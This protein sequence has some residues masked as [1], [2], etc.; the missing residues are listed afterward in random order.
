MGSIPKEVFV[1][2][3]I[4]KEPVDFGRIFRQTYLRGK[5]GFVML[6]LIEFRKII[7]ASGAIC[8]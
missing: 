8:P 4:L 5:G 7:P 2:F 6:F 3:D 1:Y